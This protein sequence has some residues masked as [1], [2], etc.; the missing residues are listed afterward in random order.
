MDV[1][2]SQEESVRLAGDN[3]LE[4]KIDADVSTE[5]SERCSSRRRLP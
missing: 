3:S 5:K 1:R 2:M 4:S